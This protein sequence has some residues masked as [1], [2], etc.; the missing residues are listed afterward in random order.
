[1]ATLAWGA[2]FSPP[3]SEDLSGPHAP[4]L[5]DRYDGALARYCGSPS[6]R[7]LA[8]APRIGITAAVARPVYIATWSSRGARWIR[9]G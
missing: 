5:L 4:T 1:M 2:R 3:Y 9:S 6:R 8:A 7:I